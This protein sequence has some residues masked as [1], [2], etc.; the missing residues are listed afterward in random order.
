MLNVFMVL[1][2]YQFQ[3]I[4]LNLENRYQ[5]K[6]TPKINILLLI[7]DFI[8]YTNIV[9]I[10]SESN[11]FHLHHQCRKVS[12]WKTITVIRVLDTAQP[13]KHSV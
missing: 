2:V 6:D 8:K 1:T 13:D 5:H 12:M 11:D 7:A 10:I 3:I 4:T 9:T